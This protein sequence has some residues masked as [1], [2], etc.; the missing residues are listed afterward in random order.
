MP[1]DLDCQV[2]QTGN[3]LGAYPYAEGERV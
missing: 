2:V 1:L 3:L